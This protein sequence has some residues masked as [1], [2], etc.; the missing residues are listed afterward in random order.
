MILELLCLN[1]LGNFSTVSC[2][3]HI[4][5][6]LFCMQA[7]VGFNIVISFLHQGLHF[8]ILLVLFGNISVSEMC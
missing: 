8:F 6:L 5:E 1:I 2:N 7:K 3:I 4:K